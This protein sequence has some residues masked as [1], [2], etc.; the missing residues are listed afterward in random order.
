MDQ[1]V[2]EQG[3]A[4]T[5]PMTQGYKLIRVVPEEVL[6]K[7][8]PVWSTCYGH[9]RGLYDPPFALQPAASVAGPSIPNAVTVATT[10]QTQTQPATPGSGRRAS[11]PTVTVGPTTTAAPIALAHTEG[12]TRQAIPSPSDCD[13]GSAIDA[14]PTT[15]SSPEEAVPADLDTESR[16]AM[17]AEATT[18]L[19]P[20]GA[21]AG[22][23]SELSASNPGATYAAPETTTGHSGGTSK[24]VGGVLASVFA[25]G[26]STVANNAEGISQAD[27]AIASTPHLVLSRQ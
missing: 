17:D 16:L 4:G 14:A 8:E 22:G 5:C 23:P 18:T 12:N 25:S 9:I 21:N 7:V 6:Q 27:P 1:S 13:Q 24:N 11:T 15:T 10:S 19:T 2:R 20:E 26:G 3:C